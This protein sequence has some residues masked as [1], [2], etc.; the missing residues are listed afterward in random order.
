MRLKAEE[1]ILKELKEYEKAL[2]KMNVSITISKD[3]EYENE[4]ETTKNILE[5]E[6]GECTKRY[7]LS[8]P[9]DSMCLRT[10]TGLYFK[11]ES[12]F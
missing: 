11:V 10:D 1:E 9:L 8:H 4:G 3:G 5:M 7:I 2:Y 12:T 6:G